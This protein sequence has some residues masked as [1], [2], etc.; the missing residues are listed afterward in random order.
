MRKGF[1]WLTVCTKSFFIT[2]I[3]GIWISNGC[4]IWR[5]TGEGKSEIHNTAEL[6]LTT[7]LCLLVI[8][9]KKKK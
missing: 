9:R 4:L 3:D 1:L 8:G 6:T 5:I 2:G 7:L